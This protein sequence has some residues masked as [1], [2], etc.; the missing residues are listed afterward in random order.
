VP[1]AAA[2]TIVGVFAMASARAAL[3][4]ANTTWHPTTPERST[5][6]VTS[7]VFGLSRNPIYLGMMLV[8]LGFAVL[9]ASPAALLAS[10]AF[11]I[12]IDRFQIEPEER[13]LAVILGQEYIDYC[14]RVRRWI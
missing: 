4:R 12:Y 10:S 11:V 6:L 2:L 14:S 7:G 5:S 8:M 3:E 13:T 9:L 1:V